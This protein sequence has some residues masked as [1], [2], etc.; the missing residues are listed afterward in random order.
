[1]DDIIIIG[2]CTIICG[3]EDYNDREKKHKKKRRIAA[4]SAEVL[5]YLSN[6]VGMPGSNTGISCSL[7]RLIL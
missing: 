7:N 2:L 6:A 5:I 3:G 1:M 4:F